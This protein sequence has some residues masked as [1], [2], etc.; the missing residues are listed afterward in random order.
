MMRHCWHDLN[1]ILRIMIFNLPNLFTCSNLIC[2]CIATYCAFHHGH[3]LAFLFILGGA[4]FDFFDGM[5]AR[6]MGKSGRFGIELD[7]L[8]DVVTFGVAPSAMIFTLFNH[9]SYPQFMASELWFSVMPFTAFLMAAASALRLAKF[10]IDERQHVDFIGL[11]TPANAIFWAALISS[12]E[13]WLTG[14]RFNAFFLFAFMILSSW[15][16]V[17]EVPMFS[18]KFQKGNPN[19]SI[20][21]IFVCIVICILVACAVV[22]VINGYVWHE[23]TKGAAISIGVYV[24]MGFVRIFLP[25]KR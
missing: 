12:S 18:L 3:T 1:K 14:P 15:L 16:L 8:A 11:P 4:F 5:L 22:G 13:A 25:G 23:L 21:K 2:G 19:N 6:A 20:K 7:S 10:N 24:L 9:V 17:C